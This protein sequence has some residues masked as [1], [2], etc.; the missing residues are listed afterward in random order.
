MRHPHNG[1]PPLS[2][3]KK[4]RRRCGTLFVYDKVYLLMLLRP[5]KPEPR[6]AKPVCVRN[7]QQLSADVHA[8]KN[9]HHFFNVTGRRL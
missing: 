1:Q 6:L 8:V 3:K 9:V 4:E 5:G 7:Y 2:P